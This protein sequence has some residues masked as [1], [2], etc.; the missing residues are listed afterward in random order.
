MK[1]G[2]TLIELLVVIAIIGILTG[3]II[4]SLN[5]A[6]ANSRDGKRLSDIAQ[7]QLALESYFDACKQ[8]P[9]ANSSNYLDGGAAGSTGPGC[10]SGVNLNTFIPSVPVAPT[11]G[12]AY[13]Y[14]PQSSS[15]S[16]CLAAVLEN[17]TNSSILNQCTFASGTV[18]GF[19]YNQS[20]AGVHRVKP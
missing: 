5:G 13:I 8:Y 1:K 7:L 19:D 6:R 4:A 14:E 16:Y 18:G 10:P 3:I 2:F 20:N 15:K 11:Q 9:P 12:K 17:T